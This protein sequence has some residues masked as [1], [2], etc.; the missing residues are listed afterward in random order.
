MKDLQATADKF[1]TL[2]TTVLFIGCS[3]GVLLYS[4]SSESKAPEQTVAVQILAINEEVVQVAEPSPSEPEPVVEPEPEPEVEPEPEPVVQKVAPKPAPKPKVQPKKKV[5]KKENRRPTKVTNSTST[6]STATNTNARLTNAPAT[7]SGN[8]R[9]IRD[10]AFNSLVARVSSL[11]EYPSRAR[12]QGIEGR[13]VLRFAV[14]ST[15]RVT[16]ASM[17]QSS[18]Q[19]LLDTACKRLASKLVGFNTGTSGGDFNVQVPITF[20]LKN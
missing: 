20:S 18:G 14:N 15:G 9:Q 13:C 6:N 4:G 7:S 17:S 11:K 8:T 2:I 5:V 12:R 16:A 3:A 10:R 19:V 1:A